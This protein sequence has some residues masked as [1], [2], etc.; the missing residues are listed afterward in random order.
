MV[1]ESI[2]ITFFNLIEKSITCHTPSF[3][4]MIIKAHT[5][6]VLHW[7]INEFQEIV[8]KILNGS[9]QNYVKKIE[10][11]FKEQKVYLAIASIAAFFEY[12]LTK[13][14]EASRLILWWALCKEVF[15]C[16]TSYDDDCMRFD[17]VFNSK[18]SCQHLM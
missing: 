8:Q 14:D 18:F 2:I 7:F 12:V 10:L 15:F 3:E 11:S 6:Q 16:E 5:L 9:L 13:L 17:K 4:T 1:K